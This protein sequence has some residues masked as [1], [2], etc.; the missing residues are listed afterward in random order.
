M[1]IN[2]LKF[3]RENARLKDWQIDIL[4]IIESESQYFLPQMKTKIMNEG[5]ASFWHYRMCHQLDLDSE[6][7]IPILKTHNQV[8][9]PHVGGL[10]PYHVGF[11]LFKKIEER[12][13]LEECFIARETLED[14]SFLRNYLTHEDCRDL[15][16]FT[17][18][19]K[20]YK[21]KAS[22]LRIL[23]LPC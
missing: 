16:L 18:S 19:K 21:N 15:G 17:F 9:R 10:N 14:T 6:Y 7:H 5:W 4:E 23:P 8:V 22:Q 3:L 11:E 2:I 13:G 20:K 12:H 1:I